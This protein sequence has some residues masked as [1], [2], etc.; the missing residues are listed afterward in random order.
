MDSGLKQ[1][2]SSP[3]FLTGPGEK[4][5]EA[6][7]ALGRKEMMVG[8]TMALC[9]SEKVLGLPSLLHSEHGLSRAS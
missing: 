7:Q 4:E 2:L 1:N 5:Q 3:I 9:L 6:E 8:Y